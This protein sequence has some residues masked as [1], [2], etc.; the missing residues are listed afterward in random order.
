MIIS[1]RTDGVTELKTSTK[2]VTLT[3]EIEKAEKKN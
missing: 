1:R 2:V 3:Q